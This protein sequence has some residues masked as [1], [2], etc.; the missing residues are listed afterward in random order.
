MPS[1]EKLWKSTS[2]EILSTIEQQKCSSIRLTEHEANKSDRCDAFANVFQ[3]LTRLLDF[4]YTLIL[5]LFVAR[6]CLREVKKAAV[7]NRPEDESSRETS[8]IVDNI[9]RRLLTEAQYRTHRH[10]I[11]F[12][13]G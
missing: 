7:F 9:V 12:T 11:S 8:H 13:F 5:Q 10:H 1:K 6:N 3:D 4:L 2:D